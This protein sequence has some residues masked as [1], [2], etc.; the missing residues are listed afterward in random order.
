MKSIYAPW[1]MEYIRGKKADGCIFCRESIRDGEFVLHDGR[2]AFIIM[3]RYP[4]ITGHL[5]VAPHRHVRNIEE[6]SLEEHCEMFELTARCVRA[7]KEAFSPQGF[8]LGMNLGRAAGAGVEDHLHMHIVPRW[9]GDTNAL[10][11]FGEVRVISE[12]LMKTKETLLPEK[13][14]HHGG[15]TERSSDGVTAARG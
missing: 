9:L 12:D 2:R 7:L 1:R 3:N 6:L 10:S 15:L 13:P 8:N 11:V 14:S 5:M 4:Y